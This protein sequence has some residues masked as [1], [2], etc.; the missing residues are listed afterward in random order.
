MKSCEV[1]DKIVHVIVMF[2]LSTILNLEQ[3]CRSMTHGRKPIFQHNGV[4]KTIFR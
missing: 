3:L 2:D 4:M 1:S